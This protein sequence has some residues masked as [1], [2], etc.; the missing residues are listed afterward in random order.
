M[1]GLVVRA[2]H[3]PLARALGGPARAL[4]PPLSARASDAG[5]P[6]LAPVRAGRAPAPPPTAEW[7]G[8]IASTPGL[9]ASATPGWGGAGGGNG[10]GGGSRY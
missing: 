1:L 6:H 7:L 5:G 10:D 3:L 4:V 2:A 8:I 9:G